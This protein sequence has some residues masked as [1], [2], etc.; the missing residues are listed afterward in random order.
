MKQS[1]FLPFCFPGVSLAPAHP[2]PVPMACTHCSLSWTLNELWLL[3]GKA[4][5]SGARGSLSKPH[6]HYSNKASPNF[7][8]G[9]HTGKE[10]DAYLTVTATA[11]LWNLLLL[12]TH[13]ASPASEQPAQS[14][15]LF[16][17]AQTGD[18]EK[19]QMISRCCEFPLFT[20]K[21]F[22]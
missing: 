21:S 18:S 1:P 20:E 4:L 5:L 10:K 17:S 14:R 6:I 12:N 16:S 15:E 11:E 19:T 8:P 7:K 22:T 9:L 2:P 3:P 13:W